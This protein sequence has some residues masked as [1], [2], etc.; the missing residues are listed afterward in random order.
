MSEEHDKEA[1]IRERR[2]R[3]NQRKTEQTRM[4]RTNHHRNEIAI[5][6][7]YKTKRNPQTSI[8]DY[9]IKC[10]R[11]THARTHASDIEQI[12]AIRK[13]MEECQGCK[14]LSK[15]NVTT[16]SSSSSSISCD[17]TGRLHAHKQ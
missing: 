11:R 6:F 4:M 7:A 13:G 10:T 9:V 14:L 17:E 16:S 1:M 2:N 12:F 8:R 15:E 3:R 5:R